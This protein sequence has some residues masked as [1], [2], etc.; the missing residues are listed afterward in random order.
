MRPTTARIDLQAIRANLRRVRELAPRSRVVAVVKADAYGH[1]AARVLPALRDADML[2]VACIEEALALREAGA[3]QP[4]LLL[5]GVFEPDELPLC[6]RLGFEIALHEPGQL[7][8]LEL[9][10]LERAL[11]VWLKLDSGMGRLGFRP[12]QAA[13]IDRR[14]RTTEA[15]AGVRLMTHLA[16]ADARGDESAR[17][18]VARLHRATAGIPGERC[19]AN[20]AGVLAWPEAHADWVRPGLMLYGASPMEACTGPGDGLRPAMTLA[21]R[22]ISVKDIRAGEPVGYGATWRAPRDG[23]I[24]VAAI[25]YADGY[26]RHL[27][28]GSPVLVNGR[29]AGTAG[30]VSMDMLAVD[31]ADRPEAQVGDIVTLWGEGL[32]IEHVAE[33]AGTIPYE[34]MCRLA[35]RV[36]VKVRDGG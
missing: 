25:G 17:E 5:E 16:N 32:P 24:G 8:M 1:G 29:L 35:A 30:R 9:A 28:S 4:V 22:L 33:R 23:R 10:R 27:P 12:E 20:S 21:T 26:P 31:L 3:R 18:Q 6:A 15:C 19:I 34:L 14:L 13:D 7:R 36:H 11:P 2:G